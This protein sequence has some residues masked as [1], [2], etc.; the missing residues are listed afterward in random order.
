MTDK[1]EKNK[2]GSQEGSEGPDGAKD[3]FG[4][5]V[6]GKFLCNTRLTVSVNED[7]DK[8]GIYQ[9]AEDKF[10]VV[11]GKVEGIGASVPEAIREFKKAYK[12]AN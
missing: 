6:N 3:L 10:R 7:L 1:N 9:L 5:P 4:D 11:K 12:A 2:P 8:V